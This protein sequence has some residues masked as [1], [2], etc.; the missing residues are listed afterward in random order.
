MWVSYGG[1]I[2]PLILAIMLFREARS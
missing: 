2:V 1:V